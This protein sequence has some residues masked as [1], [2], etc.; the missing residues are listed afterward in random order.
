MDL[1]ITHQYPDDFHDE[2]VV[3]ALDECMRV[4]P[5]HD[6]FRMEDYWELNDAMQAYLMR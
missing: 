1:F 2:F 3:A 4:L 5:D 6:L